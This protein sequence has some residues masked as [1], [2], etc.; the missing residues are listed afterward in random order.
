[1]AEYNSHICYLSGDKNTT[2]D[3]LSRSLSL[4]SAKKETTDVQIHDFLSKTELFALSQKL[5]KV[6]GNED[7]RPEEQ[8]GNVKQYLDSFKIIGLGVDL[9]MQAKMYELIHET[10]IR[11]TQIGLSVVPKLCDWADVIR[12]MHD[13]RGHWKTKE[14]IEMIKDHFWCPSLQRD[15]REHVKS[16]HP[17]QVATQSNRYHK[18][19]VQPVIA[20]FHTFLMDFTGP[21]P[22]TKCKNK[23]ILLAVEHLT[24]WPI[25][26]EIKSETSVPAIQFFKKV[27]KG[28][29][30]VLESS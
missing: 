29:L 10:L 23:R 5:S 15:P 18:D 4:E 6:G 25:T 19:G 28:R 24:G 2:A 7:N 13:E 21:F 17:Y 8:L 14:T 1:M 9:P 20:L 27:I 11:Q 3:Y 16:C 30:E 22:T 12:A 26:R